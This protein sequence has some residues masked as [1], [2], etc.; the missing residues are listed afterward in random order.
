MIDK[1]R[2]IISCMLYF[3]LIPILICIGVI[4]FKNG[5]YNLISIFTA[6]IVC[7]PFF[8]RFEKGKS[9]AREL[10]VITV[11]TAISVTGRLIFAPI[12]GFK[13]VTAIV[14]ITALALGSEA[15]FAVGAL[16]AIVSNI[17]FGQGAWTPFQMFV[18]GFI[19]FVAGFFKSNK[20]K[21]NYVLL[22]VLG[23]LGGMAF[24]LIMDMYTMLSIDNEWNWSRYL[25]YLISGL[26]FLTMYCVSNIVFLI[27][28]TKP[29]TSK[30]NRIKIKYNLQL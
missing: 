10:V 18:W 25:T 9:S 24:S 16:S 15:G 14:I 5:R 26:P 2:R 30:L 20:S 1:K 12:P 23:I 28:M 17:F 11:M 21:R 3:I 4:L 19:G 6:F 27:V 22:I 29:I 13:P 7:I 8:I